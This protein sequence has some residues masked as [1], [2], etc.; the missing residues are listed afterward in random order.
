M[1]N[2]FSSN[3]VSICLC[4]ASGG[5]AIGLAQEAERA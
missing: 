5:A 4:L 3:G 2:A 1:L